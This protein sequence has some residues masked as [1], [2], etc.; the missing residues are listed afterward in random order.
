MT[1]L[2][3]E[4]INNSNCDKTK[5]NPPV[6]QLKNSKYDKTNNQITTNL[7]M[8]IVTIIKNTNCDKTQVGTKL[9]ISNCDKTQ[10]FNLQQ[11][12]KTSIIIKTEKNYILIK[13]LFQK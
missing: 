13:N 12:S 7:I 11:N 4:Y 8:P 5:K 10:A 3:I 9:N 2:K 6:T 1:K